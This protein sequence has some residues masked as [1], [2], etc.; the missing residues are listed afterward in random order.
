MDLK[1]SF[2]DIRKKAI[3][4]IERSITELKQECGE[5]PQGFKVAILLDHI[6]SKISFAFCLGLI[7]EDEEFK[8]RE[9]SLRM[10]EA[11]I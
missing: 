4:Q 3:S 1:P 11:T 10:F 8:Y 9:K 5:D 6:R 7:T 2:D